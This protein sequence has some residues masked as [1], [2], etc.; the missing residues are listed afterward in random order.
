MDLFKDSLSAPL[1]R[2]E[3]KRRNPV[4]WIA[5]FIFSVLVLIGL[6]APRAM[7]WYIKKQE[8][9]SMESQL[10]LKERELETKKLE[11][12]NLKIEF[13]E[14]SKPYLVRESQIFPKIVD[15]A[16]VAKILEIYSLQLEVLDTSDRDSRFKVESISFGARKKEKGE[17]YT[18]IDS[19]LSFSTDKENLGEFIWFLQTGLISERFTEG[20]ESG[21]IDT[22]DFKFL[23]DNLLPLIH[24]DSIAVAEDRRDKSLFNVQMKLKIFSQLAKL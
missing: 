17:N 14:Q 15:T 20:K 22:A 9:R 7:E 23:E 18:Y 1:S 3:R 13:E 12:N 6:V 16:K 21:I 10:S 5:L 8:V 24:I 19:K 4:P 2:Q 11:H